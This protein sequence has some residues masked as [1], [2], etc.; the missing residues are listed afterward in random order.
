MER[1]SLYRYIN[2][3]NFTLKRKNVLAEKRKNK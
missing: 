3:F 1:S 2:M